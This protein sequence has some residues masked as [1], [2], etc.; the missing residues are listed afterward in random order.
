MFIKCREDILPLWP[1]RVEI[2]KYDNNQISMIMISQANTLVQLQTTHRWRYVKTISNT[3][4]VS[5]CCHNAMSIRE[6]F[7][8]AHLK[9]LSLMSFIFP[10]PTPPPLHTHRHIKSSCYK[11]IRLHIYVAEID[12]CNSVWELERIFLFPHAIVRATAV[13]QYGL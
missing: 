4:H 8:L 6:I 13:L 1:K 2:F 10:A 3:S 9:T 11:K 5:G 7:W 12:G